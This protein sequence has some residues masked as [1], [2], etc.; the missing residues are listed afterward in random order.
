V[1]NGCGA[2]LADEA[3]VAEAGQVE[4]GDEPRYPF[5]G[6]QFGDR[7]SGRRPGLEAV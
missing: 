3:A 4:S 1:A 2:L 6:D 7:L 5:G